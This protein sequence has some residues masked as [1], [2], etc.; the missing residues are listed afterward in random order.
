MAFIWTGHR[1][2]K[3]NGILAITNKRILLIQL[4]KSLSMKSKFDD[5]RIIN[6]DGF[7]IQEQT[8]FLKISPLTHNFPYIYKPFGIELF[9]LSIHLL[10]G[11]DEYKA[12]VST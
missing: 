3:K 6:L 7:Q 4:K 9:A 5:I 10:H 8:G 2:K 11:P 1:E 12:S